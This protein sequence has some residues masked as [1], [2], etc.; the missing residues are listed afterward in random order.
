VSDPVQGPPFALRTAVLLSAGTE[1]SEGVI[2]NTHFRFLGS[3]LK[4]LGISVIKGVQVPDEAPLFEAELRLA[5]EQSDL[6]VV[7]GGLGP[8]SDD[9][10]REI[11]ATVAEVPL[12]FREE[13]WNELVR[14]FSGGNAHGRPI[15]AANR[16]QVQVPAGFDAL[17][18]PHGTAPGFCGRVGRSLLVALPGPPVELEPMFLDQVLPRLAPDG[19]D[20][21]GVRDELTGTVLLTPESVLEETLQHLRY[22]LP[23]A[24]GV[25]WGTRVAEDRIELTLRAGA[26]GAK[27]IL[28]ERLQEELGGLLVRRGLGRPVERLFEL[29]RRDGLTASF[30]ESCTGGLL[31]KLMTDI[32]GS[33]QVFWGAVVT[34]DNEAKKRLLSVETATLDR[35]G[36]VSREV[37]EAMS[38]GLLSLS[39][40]DLGVAV[41]GI[42]GPEGGGPEK[43]VGTV[44]ISARTASGRHSSSGFHFR[45]SRDLVRRRSAVA[46]FLV[47]ECLLTDADPSPLQKLPW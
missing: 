15:A 20:A 27:E 18:N 13:L 43:P 29:L 28:F 23:Q 17:R 5:L 39:G 41:T 21:S 40:T 37:V 12:E 25:L 6:V 38:A 8:T 16:R 10:T 31:S 11:V 32:P 9:L 36:A 4:S 42:A 26:P 44:W 7:T 1:L 35:F 45:G 34:Y 47:A 14:R 24:S 33:S 30:A 22:R 19:P 2:L 46:A 3:A